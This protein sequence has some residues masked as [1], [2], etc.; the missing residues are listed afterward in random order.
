MVAAAAQLLGDLLDVVVVDM[1][2]TAGPDE[3]PHVESGLR[4]HHVGE[5]R[6]AGDVERHA[7]EQVG[8]ALIQLAGQ[9][10][11][12]DV[13]LEERMARRQRHLRDLADVPGRDDVAARVRIGLEQLQRG[14]DLVDVLAR[15][16]RPRPPLHAVHR[17]QIPCLR[18]PFVP[19]RHAMLLQP[20][21][22]GVTAQ[23]PQQ[24]V[25]DRLGVHLLGGDQ[26][27]S[28]RQVV[29]QLV[30]EQA[31]GAGAGTVRFRGP[32]LEYQAE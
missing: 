9:P 30:A 25:D 13:E 27:E 17:T 32:V 6:I 16:R 21:H 18:G 3:L 10:A 29:A 22:V 5:Q 15:R 14:A 7:E 4:R 24:L 23:E 12:G 1:A 26:R 8:A 19:D 28:G 31:A 2:V 11:V 20:A